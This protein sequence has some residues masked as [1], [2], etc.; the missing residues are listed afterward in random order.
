MIQDGPP[1]QELPLCPSAQPT[2]D[3][4]VVF[5]IVGGTVEAPTVRYVNKPLAVTE[6][7]LTLAEPVEPTEVFRFAAPCA[8][9]A[10]KHFD[11]TN[12]RL[13]RRVVDHLPEVTDRLPPCRIRPHCRWWQQEGREA[14]RRCPQIVTTTVFP[15]DRLLEVA[16]PADNRR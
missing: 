16:L 5:G 7:V 3:D 8:T 15:S 14:C 11:G 4:A 6:G 13:A 1:D 2:M 9:G 12:C 10:C